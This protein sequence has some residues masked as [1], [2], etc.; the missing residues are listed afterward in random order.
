MAD[1]KDK[2]AEDKAPPNPNPNHPG[3]PKTAEQL[4]ADQKA[5]A[6]RDEAWKKSQQQQK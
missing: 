4:A 5:Q 3:N 2:E 6:D 1:P